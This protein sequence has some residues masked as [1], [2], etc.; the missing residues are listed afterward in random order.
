[1]VVGCSRFSLH[2]HTL[3]K[4]SSRYGYTATLRK[5]LDTCFL[6]PHKVRIVHTSTA[7]F[8]VQRFHIRT[9]FFSRVSS[10]Q[11]IGRPFSSGC[12]SR[13]RIV[14]NMS[15]EAPSTATSDPRPCSTTPQPLQGT[16]S[17]VGSGDRPQKKRKYEEANPVEK[18][19]LY[20]YYVSS[21]HLKQVG[22][23]L[24]GLESTAT[25]L[26]DPIKC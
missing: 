14:V 4:L 23:A 16:V 1:M 7:L 18:T 19:E 17:S 3:P 10:R 22:D 20:N 2:R 15:C 9:C 12:R 24:L 13:I 26:G 5:H 11:P 6:Q 25:P 8:H 21:P